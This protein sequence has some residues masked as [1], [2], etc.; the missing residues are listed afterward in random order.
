MR[1]LAIAVL[2]LA[3]CSGTITRAPSSSYLPWGL[4]QGELPEPGA[5]LRW[6]DPRFEDTHAPRP[7]DLKQVEI[8]GQC[9]DRRLFPTHP[10]QNSKIY[11]VFRTAVYDANGVP[12]DSRVCKSPSNERCALT[13]IFEY[14]VISDIYQ[15]ACGGLYRGVWSVGFLKQDDNKDVLFAKGRTVYPREGA[16]FSG[17][18]EDGGTK[19]VPR[20][21]FLF[22][23]PPFPGDAA[24]AA[25]LARAAAATHTYDSA[26]HLFSK[27]K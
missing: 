15:D 19:A 11:H 18:V 10:Q 22:L 3:G 9:G 27:R 4:T 16:T 1:A 13:D 5:V 7:S 25:R 6:S 12:G 24:A 21:E 23:T 17:D 14:A 26:T 8:P 2:F 20:S